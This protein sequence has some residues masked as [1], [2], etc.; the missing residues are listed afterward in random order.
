MRLITASIILFVILFVLYPIQTLI[1]ALSIV[2]A[3]FIIR[4]IPKSKNYTNEKFYSNHV[5]DS[6]K[7][8]LEAAKLYIAPYNSMWCN[9]RLTNNYISLR[10]NTNGTRI[11]AK[12]LNNPTRTLDVVHSKIHSIGKLWEML[13]YRFDNQLTFDGLAE[14]L[15]RYEVVVNITGSESKHNS[16]SDL[17]KDSI[18][19]ISE[20]IGVKSPKIDIN[21]ATEE[22]ISNLSGISVILA[23]KIIKKQS[24]N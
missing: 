10:L 21:N 2:L 4:Q 22:E 1:T 7:R 8:A 3:V 16:E 23:K 19:M 14:I 15:E 9:L 13:C 17:K 20:G 18:K 24:R 6:R 5:I 12:E 11:Y